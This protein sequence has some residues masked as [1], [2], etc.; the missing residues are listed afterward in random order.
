MNDFTRRFLAPTCLLGALLTLGSC[1]GAT[2]VNQHFTNRTGQTLFLVFKADEAATG[3][4]FDTLWTLEPG[5]T[6]TPYALDAWGK[7]H[8]CT[9]YEG[10]PFGIDT[11]W[12]AGQSLK[13][14]LQD[15]LLWTVQVDEGLSWIRFD[16]RLDLVPSYFE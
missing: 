6:Q 1:E 13:V 11:L 3:W 15:S 2:Y 8:D 7:C 5:V 4:G 9:L 14:D 12:V 16:Q 10:L